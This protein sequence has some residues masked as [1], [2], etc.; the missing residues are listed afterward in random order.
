MNLRIVPSVS[1]SPTVIFSLNWHNLPSSLPLPTF[2]SSQ[3]ASCQ[4]SNIP[5]P[6]NTLAVDKA[7]GF[8]LLIDSVTFDLARSIV[9]VAWLDGRSQEWSIDQVEGFRSSL[10]EVLECVRKSGEEAEKEK[11]AAAAAQQSN[12]ASRSS[13]SA[14]SQSTSVSSTSDNSAANG[15]KRHR[16]ASGIFSSLVAS[17]ITPPPTASNSTPS[18][19]IPDNIPPHLAHLYT[20]RNQRRKNSTTPLYHKQH[21]NHPKNKWEEFPQNKVPQSRALRRQAR[22][23]LVDIFRYFVS[24]RLMEQMRSHGIVGEELKARGIL[25]DI[26]ADEGFEDGGIN[27]GTGGFSAA[28]GYVAHM[29]RSMLRTSLAEAAKTDDD[30]FSSSSEE[31]LLLTPKNSSNASLPTDASSQKSAS[32]PT[33]PTSR[34][35]SPSPASKQ[36]RPARRAASPHVHQIRHLSS[37]LIGLTQK[38]K[39]ASAEDREMLEMVKE[40]SLRRRWS[41]YETASTARISEARVRCVSDSVIADARARQGKAAEVLEW[42]RP[43]VPSP[44]RHSEVSASEDDD[45]EIIVCVKPTPVPFPSD[46]IVPFPS[47]VSRGAAHGARR[48]R[49]MPSPVTTPLDEEAET[50]SH[51]K[52]S[53]GVCAFD[54]EESLALEY[55][56]TNITFLFRRPKDTSATQTVAAKPKAAEAEDVLSA[57]QQSRPRRSA[58]LTTPPLSASSSPASSPPSSPVPAP[59]SLSSARPPLSSIQASAEEESNMI[60]IHSMPTLPSPKYTEFPEDDIAA[61]GGIQKRRLGMVIT[62]PGADDSD[63]FPTDVDAELDDKSG[64]PPPSYVPVDV[65]HSDHTF[66]DVKNT[67]SPVKGLELETHSGEITTYWSRASDGIYVV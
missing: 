37:V 51:E 63:D 57:S 14:S 42:T 65:G 50:V 49:S 44:L 9:I 17:F 66:R 36:T 46:P 60:T 35:S 27:P 11:K 22:A 7:V 1:T 54:D 39:R 12:A 25:D 40:R 6:R 15:Q 31:S 62:F 23:K 19:P 28:G 10:E 30:S 16:T 20:F 59:L 53:K 26:D 32:R 4:E 5:A 45:E 55:C 47:S 8:Q 18:T 67:E 41:L 58:L 2:Y 21:Y 56:L 24:A 48:T 61:D 33:S 38:D 43:L 13:S 64:S 3:L 52:E 34:P 29:A